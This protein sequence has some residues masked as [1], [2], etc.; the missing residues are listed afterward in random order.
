MPGL[1]R[2]RF[3]FVG[4]DPLIF[5]VFVLLLFANTALGLSLN[6]LARYFLSKASAALAP[7]ESLASGG[8]QYHAP[9]IV[10][11]Y[12]DWWLGMQFILLGL[13]AL[14]FVIFRMRVHHI[15]MHK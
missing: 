2:H 12:A 5:R 15:D 11:W 13:I 7:C 14:V 3:E 8:V 6:F 9:G 4:K 10:C 1:G